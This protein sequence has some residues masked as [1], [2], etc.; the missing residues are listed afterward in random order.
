M[1]RGTTTVP[2]PP[3]GGVPAAAA[4]IA[5]ETLCAI[6]PGMTQTEM[7]MKVLTE[8]EPAVA[9]LRATK[10]A[11]TRDIAARVE[12]VLDH[13]SALARAAGLGRHPQG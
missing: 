11:S 6:T 8:P 5:L 7:I 10:A 13:H 1:K 4:W 9:M 2:A 12:V 3:W